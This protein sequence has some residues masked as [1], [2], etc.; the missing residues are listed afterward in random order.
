MSL[1]GVDGVAEHT[2]HTGDMPHG[3][4]ASPRGNLQR[5]QPFDNLAR[6]Q[7]FLDQPAKHVPHD[8]G[9]FGMD[10]HSWREPGVFGKI[11][12]AIRPVRPRQKCSL[13]RFMQ[14]SAARPVGNLAPFVFGHH[15]L[16]LCQELTV[17]RIPKGIF[18]KDD[19]TAELLEF[20][21]EQPLMRIAAG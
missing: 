11:P 20:F 21:Q 17:G 19:A 4:L 6:S 14:P 3:V 16:H 5:V 18:H 8:F 9:L 12:V 1:P 7:L 15:P 13:P 10:F 2:A